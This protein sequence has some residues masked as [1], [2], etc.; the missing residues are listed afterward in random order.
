VQEI[1]S[2]DEISPTLFGSENA[3]KTINF[4][5]DF[6]RQEILRQVQFSSRFFIARNLGEIS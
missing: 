5:E 4:L 2:K 1:L 3:S 6:W